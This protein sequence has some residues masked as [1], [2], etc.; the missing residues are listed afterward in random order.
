MDLSLSFVAGLLGSMH[1][2][3]MCGA[4]VLA[5]STGPSGDTGTRGTY[6]PGSSLL[7][8]LPS[9]LM[10]NGGRVLS[11]MCI[12]GLVG[13]LGGLITAIQTIG[14]LFSVVG[15]MVMVTAGL[16]MLD[17]IPRTNRSSKGR[18]SLLRRF[19]L[20]SLASLLSF[21]SL[22]SKF[23]IGVLT[24]FLPCGL[25]YSMFVQAA[26][27]GGIVNGALTMLVFGAG[28]VPALLVTG[29]AS[30]Y[31]GLKLRYYANKLAAMTIILMGVVM[32]LRGL[33]VPVP[34]MERVHEGHHGGDTQIIR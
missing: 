18:E 14:T 2:I 29:L 11:Y 8:T 5:Y 7:H 19:H 23:Y 12:G 24:P 6:A 15:G 16:L 21:R 30:A 4:V 26:G 1:C 13:Y 17:V 31:M 3:G 32:L 25:L 10:Y 33:G 20:D 9:H 27:S 34:F 22:M 28:I